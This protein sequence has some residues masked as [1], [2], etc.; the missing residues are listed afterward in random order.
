[1]L[2][3]AMLAAAILCIVLA[4]FRSLFQRLL[5]LLSLDVCLRCYSLTTSPLS[6]LKM[7][8]REESVLFVVERRRSVRA[9]KIGDARVEHLHKIVEFRVSNALSRRASLCAFVRA[10][11]HRHW[12]PGTEVMA[13]FLYVENGCKGGPLRRRPSIIGIGERCMLALEVIE[14]SMVSLAG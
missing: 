13:K 14:L 10:K 1:M 5:A 7:N 2:A 11:N 3:A 9:R 4:L 12:P 8:R 6:F